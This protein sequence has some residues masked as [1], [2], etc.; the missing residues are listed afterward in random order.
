MSVGLAVLAAYG[1]DVAT[2]APAGPARVE[3]PVKEVKA[4]LA[5]TIVDP[6]L[7]NMFIIAPSG[8]DTGKVLADGSAYETRSKD[9]ELAAVGDGVL[10]RVP[11]E[12]VA[13]IGGRK[14]K[15][16][17]MARSSPTN[18]SPMAKVMYFRPGS[19]QGS[20]R[21]DVTLTSKFTP[22]TL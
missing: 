16:K 18:V 11:A 7:L 9:V 10:V 15:V 4:K 2:R 21:Q 20:S 6:T 3:R 12:A 14:V 13:Q 19:E 5:V 8:G 17:V 1:E 22:F